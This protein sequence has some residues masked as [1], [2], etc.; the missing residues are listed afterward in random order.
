M[1]CICCRCKI[2]FEAEDMH[3]L[4]CRP[5]PKRIFGQSEAWSVYVCPPCLKW[6]HENVAFVNDPRLRG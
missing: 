1:T 2:E 5:D 6:V 4:S 3:I